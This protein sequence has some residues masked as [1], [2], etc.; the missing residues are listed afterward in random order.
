MRHHAGHCHICGH[1]DSDQIDHII[2]V[3]TWLRQHREGSPHRD[4][5]LAPIHQ[6]PCPHCGNHCHISKTQ[7][8]AAASRTRLTRKRTPE[9]HPGLIA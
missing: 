4:S 3:A 5:N 7:T 9:K 2:N 6:Q 1:P 8:E